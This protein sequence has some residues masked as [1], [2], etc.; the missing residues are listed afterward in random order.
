MKLSGLSWQPML[1]FARAEDGS[2]PARALPNRPLFVFGRAATLAALALW[3]VGCDEATLSLLPL[4]KMRPTRGDTALVGQWSFDTDMTD[5]V[6][7]ND[8]TPLGTA[9]I[10]TD[11]Q[12]GNVLACDGESGGV[13]IANQ[14][15]NDFSYALWMW[16]NVSSATGANAVDGDALLWA[17]AVNR[18]DDFTLALL[19]DKLSYLSYSQTATGTRSLTDSVWH[20]VVLTRRDTQRVELYVDGELDGDGNAGTGPVLATLIVQLCGNPMEGHYFQ[21]KLDDVRSFNR[22]LSAE[23]A[24]ALYLATRL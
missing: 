20:H 6:G 4:A 19:N 11:S 2:L 7:T 18:L 8:G 17:N 12:R 16:T 22:V 23:E 14:T 10:V 21:G 1:A 13:S 24:R 9:S 5:Q 15:T 3:L